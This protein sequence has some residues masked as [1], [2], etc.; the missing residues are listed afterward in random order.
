MKLSQKAGN[1][2]TLYGNSLL[3][4]LVR[5]F[6]SL[7]T[8][9][10]V[11]IFSRNI[12]ETQYGDYQ[13]FWVHLY[14]LSSLATMGIPA[15][16]LTYSPAFVKQLIFTLK[17]KHYILML[18]WV[19]ALAAVFV[20]T[21]H[22][23]S[24]T[25]WYI[26]FWFF[27]LY[28]VNAITESILIVYRKYGFLLWVNLAYTIVF[29]WLHYGVLTGIFS[30]DNL[31]YYLLLPLLLKLLIT[32]PKLNSC[33]KATQA[34]DVKHY[35]IA[36]IRSLWMHIGIYDVLQRVF[37]WMDKFAISLLFGAGVSAIYFNGTFDIPFLPLLLGAVSG[38]A[39]MQMSGFANKDD[40]TGAIS[41]V[42]Q[43]ARILSAVVF[44]LFF[45]LFLFRDEL[46]TVLLTNKY[47]AAIP[48]FAVT[49]CIVPLRAYN[50]TSVLQNRH[51]GNIIN[52]GAVM[53]IVL[54]VALMYPLYQM[55]ELTGI[56]MS[57]VISS[58]VQGGYYLYHTARILDIP[59]LKLIP[60]RNWFV[61]LIVFS[62]LFI[63]I[64]YILSL[65]F[66]QTIVLILGSLAMAVIVLVTLAI[67][68][69]ASKKYYGKPF[70]ET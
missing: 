63:A 58:Y 64:H 26:P 10:V 49:V 29:L 14:L 38:A 21:R 33:L 65:Q 1:N 69:R 27:L 62:I 2:N 39:L 13:N 5:F 50:F 70:S 18:G 25:D 43:T 47:A 30:I 46:F 6:P 34:E 17:A 44:P 11:I 51:K 9:V 61:K 32:W 20:G 57:F 54:A 59:V 15:F 40:N 12:S 53:D 66:P 8:L 45:F 19:I 23:T 24:A 55:F 67:E 52:T 41:V 3:I 7:A 35:T 36:E 60:A 68:I 37:T 56:A 48:I 31:F 22:Y 42:N 16:L 4:F 28:T